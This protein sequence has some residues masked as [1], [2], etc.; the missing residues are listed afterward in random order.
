MQSLSW[1]LTSRRGCIAK[2]ATPQQLPMSEAGPNSPPREYSAIASPDDGLPPPAVEGWLVDI[3][4]WATAVVDC[5]PAVDFVCHDP[6]SRVI[7]K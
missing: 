7:R 3:V 1:R 5:L 6:L 4:E 2:S